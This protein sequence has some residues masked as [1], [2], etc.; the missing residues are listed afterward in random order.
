MI[1][2]FSYGTHSAD[3][4][5]VAYCTGGSGPPLLLLHGF[6]QT[7][8]MWAQIAPKLAQNFTVIC[9]DLRG[10]GASGTLV[11]GAVKT[12]RVCNSQRIV[13]GVFNQRIAKG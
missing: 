12:Q 5:D 1:A 8:M 9:A 2:G 7:H 10:Y 3:G 11:Y 13:R 6:P 4:V